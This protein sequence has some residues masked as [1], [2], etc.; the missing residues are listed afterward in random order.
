[1]MMSVQIETMSLADLDAVL[2]LQAQ[3]YDA[4]LLEDADFYANRLALAQASCWVARADDAQVCG[5]LISYPWD[6]GLPPALNARLETLP[7]PADT[8]FLHDCAVAPRMAGRGVASSM[9]AFGRQWARMSGMRR[10]ALVSLA[11]ACR[12]WSRHGFEPVTITPGSP[13]ADKLAGYGTGASWMT[14]AL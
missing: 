12:Y 6:A 1:M 5:Y 7:Q 3:V 11:H 14:L 4:D 13:V 2:A 8:W 9:L 10:A